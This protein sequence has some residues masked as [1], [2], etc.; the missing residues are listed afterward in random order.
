M[1]IINYFFVSLLLIIQ[2][3]SAQTFDLSDKILIKHSISKVLIKKVQPL[4]DEGNLF[5]GNKVDLNLGYD[6]SSRLI[7][8]QQSSDSI[9]KTTNIY[10]SSQVPFLFITKTEVK[11][12]DSMV[13]EFLNK[14]ILINDSC[15]LNG[16]Y[17][18]YIS[19]DDL[20]WYLNALF[21]K[22]G[23][24]DKYATTGRQVFLIEELKGGH[25]LTES[26]KQ[27]FLASI[28][29][30]Y[31]VA[32]DEMDSLSGHVRMYRY[33]YNSF[34]YTKKD[35]L[36]NYFN[37]IEV[38]KIVGKRIEIEDFFG[39]EIKFLKKRKPHSVV[40]YLFK[41]MNLTLSIIDPK[42]SWK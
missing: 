14:E 40:L 9:T 2:S 8:I 3:S 28:F 16:N 6:K 10:Y 22:G 12:S 18:K 41:S 35:I 5:K 34:S 36:N 27:N 31:A 21:N 17:Y 13:I 15:V 26:Q 1:K 38:F 20:N 11:K 19:D 37:S 25:D 24:I 23:D 39:N 29:T 4:F 30:S 42:H 32:T 7:L 33:D